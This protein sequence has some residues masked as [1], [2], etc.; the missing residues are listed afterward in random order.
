MADRNYA[1]GIIIH[2]NIKGMENVEILD[3]SIT[4]VPGTLQG[5]FKVAGIRKNLWV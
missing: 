5:G 1:T 2:E 3:D 4:P